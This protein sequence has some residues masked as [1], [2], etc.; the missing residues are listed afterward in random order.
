MNDKSKS[1][2]FMTA[3]SVAANASFVLS[4]RQVTHGT[5]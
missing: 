2:S 3:R 1:I 4:E 5:V